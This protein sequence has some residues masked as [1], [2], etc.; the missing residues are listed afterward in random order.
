MILSASRRT[1]IPAFH[2]P[3]FLER[4]KAGFAEVPNPFIPAKLRRVSL[5]PE[6][7]DSVV[8]WTKDGRPLEKHFAE[9]AAFGLPCMILYTLTPYGRDIEPGLADKQGAAACLLRLAERLGPDSVVWRYDPIILTSPD[10]PLKLTAEF[11]LASF[12]AL[13]QKLEGRVRRCITSF[14]APYRRVQKNLDAMGRVEPCPQEARTLLAALGAI[15]AARGMSLQTCAAP[16]AAIP[17]AAAFSAGSRRP[18]GDA[19][20]APPAGH[21]GV[22]LFAE[23]NGAAQNASPGAVMPGACIDAGLISRILGRPLNPGRDKNQRP[24]CLCAKSVDI[25]SYGTCG[26]GCVYCYAGG[27][28]ARAAEA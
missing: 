7:V 2:F 6:D 12:E 27:A 10:A 21:F 22:E 26:H 11:H 18:A 19:R 1:D 5:L 3:W 28:P 17:G 24:A 16:E 20:A 25:G 8:F 4:L 23:E 14:V 13:A 9:F 15:A